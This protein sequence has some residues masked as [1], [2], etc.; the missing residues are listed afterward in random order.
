MMHGG[1]KIFKKWATQFM[2]N[3]LEI[4][5]IFVYEF[6]VSFCKSKTSNQI[7]LKNFKPFGFCTKLNIYKF[8]QL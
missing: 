1:I 8:H 6:Q 3:S 5:E 2:E 7:W 4:F